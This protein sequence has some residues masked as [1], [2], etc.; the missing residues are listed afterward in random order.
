MNRAVAAVAVIVIIVVAG[1]AVYAGLT[2]PRE[3]LNVPASFSVGADSQTASLDQPFLM[4]KAQVKVDVQSGIAV[5]RVQILSGDQ[6]I[7]EH[8]SAQGGQVTYTSEWIELPMGSYNLTLALVGAGSLD[9]TVAV[10]SKGG[11]W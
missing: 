2:Y 9:A 4:D 3:T 7:W 5:W 6:V 10:T 11:F 8:T 1:F